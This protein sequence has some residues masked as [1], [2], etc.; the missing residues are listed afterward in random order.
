MREE[1]LHTEME[2]KDKGKLEGSTE[3]ETEGKAHTVPLVRAGLQCRVAVLLHSKSLEANPR[4]PWESGFLGG[5]G[6][7]AFW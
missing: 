4:L 5:G 1:G 7:Q 6:E 3:R 2:T